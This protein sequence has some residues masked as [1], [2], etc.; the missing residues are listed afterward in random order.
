MV[1]FEGRKPLP[2]KMIAADLRPHL[3][4]GLL[5]AV[6]VPGPGVPVHPVREGSVRPAQVP[7]VQ[8]GVVAVAVPP[9]TLHMVNVSLDC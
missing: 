9:A 5:E 7:A 6:V 3:H 8:V 4:D 1:L 2:V